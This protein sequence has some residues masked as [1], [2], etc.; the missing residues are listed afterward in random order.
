MSALYKVGRVVF[1]GFFLYSGINHFL[2]RDHMAQYTKAKGVPQPEAAVIASGA[3][4]TLAGASLI[5]GLKPKLGSAAVSTFLATAS[6]LMHDFWKS[7]DPAARQNDL[8][9]F[10]KNL[11]LLGAALAFHGSSEECG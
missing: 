6:P 4:L 11:A 1:G 5:L 10:S 7:N 8:I 3:L 9:H 2:H